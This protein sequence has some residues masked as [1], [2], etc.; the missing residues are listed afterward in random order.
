MGA[1]K[2]SSNAYKGG[3]NGLGYYTDKGLQ[4]ALDGVKAN[5]KEDDDIFHIVQ[6]Q[7]GAGKSLFALQMAFYVD[8]S[9][10]L[11]RVCFNPEQFIKAV[12]NAKPGQAVV[13]DEAYGL[14]WRKNSTKESNNLHELI[15]L[16]RQR[17][18][19]VIVVL[20]RWGELSSDIA[21]D[22]SNG[23]FHIYRKGNIR[24]SW[25]CWGRNGKAKMHPLVKRKK[26]IN[27]GVRPM[28]WGKFCHQY[29]ID[30]KEY[31]KKKRQAFNAFLK[32]LQPEIEE[33]VSQKR[34]ESEKENNT[35]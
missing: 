2:G 7:E 14:S 31:R 25:C 1:P 30:E 20:P 33:K 32:N 16:M 18:L 28:L 10:T 27:V 13:F 26:T 17:N 12:L 11:D 24:G 35:L 3:N 23:L 34:L 5:L 9:F 22:R 8:N 6:G 21:V 29:P 4:K 19:Y 15:T